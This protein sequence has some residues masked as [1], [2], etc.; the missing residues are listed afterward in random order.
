MDEKRKYPMYDS[1][2][3]WKEKKKII[4]AD[5]EKRKKAALKKKKQVKRDT[6]TEMSEEYY[7]GYPE[8][9]PKK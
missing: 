6:T 9:R 1:N 4:E 2:L 7:K 8:R 3:P 5:I